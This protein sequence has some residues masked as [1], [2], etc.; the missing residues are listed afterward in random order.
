MQEVGIYME[1]VFP[2]QNNQKRRVVVTG[3]G[4]ISALGFLLDEFWD[5]CAAGKSGITPFS[6][7]G[8]ALSQVRFSG[9]IN[10]FTGHIDNFGSLKDSKKRA[11]RKGQKLMSREI[12][13][14]VAAAERALVDAR[15]DSDS[16]PSSRIG[17]SFASDYIITTPEEVQ[18]GMRA[19]NS[20]GNLDFTRWARDGMPKM[21]PIWQLK[22]LTN[23][24]ASHICIYNQIFGFTNAIT[25]RE[26]SIGE[27]VGEATEIIRNGKL[28]VMVVGATG[29]RVHPF[30][31]IHFLQNDELADQ[32]LSPETACRPFDLNR[33]GTVPGEGAGA[34]ILEDLEH[35]Q[36]RGATIYAEV[37]GGAYRCV[38]RFQTDNPNRCRII[39]DTEQSLVLTLRSLFQ[40][41]EAT[42][43]E[44]GHLNVC[45]FGSRL[46]D[47]AESR[48]I[49]TVFG[50]RTDSLPI[51]TLKGHL[52]NP[53]AGSGA[54]ELIA[55]I[56]SLNHRA[57]LP[58]LNYQNADPECPIYPV[59]SFGYDPGDS[60]IKLAY[61]TCGQSSAI[62][63]KRFV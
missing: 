62:L 10:A 38:S 49:R 33:T 37:V 6:L 2:E 42:P 43:E 3:L 23:M 58:V 21:T 51:T 59:R 25:G 41:T 17:V 28:D 11:I 20:N 19:C 57:L 32:T 12:M 47:A 14:G 29:S 48:A 52:G 24:P 1:K 13:M 16:I 26:A 46:G 63:V 8:T 7:P 5:A 4:I 54:L 34:L 9:S 56:M 27:A 60:F 36:Q 55:G 18:D 35:A 44:I 31:L 45:G 40:K 50:N 53:G 30:Q 39:G 15:I 22:Y 61:E